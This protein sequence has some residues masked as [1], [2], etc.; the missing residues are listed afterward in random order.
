HTRSYGDWSS[1]VCSSDLFR[2]PSTASRMPKPNYGIDAP[3][4]VR[5]L[6]IGAVAC[7]IA[8]YF[9]AR[10]FLGPAFGFTFAVLMM[11][12]SS[13]FGKFRARDSLLNA[14]PWRGDEQVL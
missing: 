3:T 5:N 11:L 6:A 1:D 4:V 14:I 13:L 9:V 7:Y 10:G 12:W 8:A 2:L